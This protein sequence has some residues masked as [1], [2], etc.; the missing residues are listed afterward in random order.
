MTELAEN[1]IELIMSR[2]EL[3]A[4]QASATLV[5]FGAVLHHVALTKT[6]TTRHPTRP[7]Q[8]TQG[9]DHAKKVYGVKWAESL[10]KRW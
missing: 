4:P 2:K 8:A 7:I 5:K 10:W 9:W 3:T 6:N 1:A